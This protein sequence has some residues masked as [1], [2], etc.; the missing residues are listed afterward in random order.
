MT[1]LLFR[2][3]LDRIPG[4]A[5]GT[6]P[7]QPPQLTPN[8]AQVLKALCGPILTGQPTLIP[9][10]NKEIAA[11]VHLSVEAV[12]GCL[13]VLST[14]F[15]IGNLPQNEKRASLAAEAIKRGAVAPSHAMPPD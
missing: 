9:A 14:K 13:R 1:T 11:Q 6:T 7:E 10:T 3:P 15:G 12:K 4:T 8:Q 2:T 5:A